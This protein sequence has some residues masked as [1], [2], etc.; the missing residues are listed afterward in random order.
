MK[1]KLTLICLLFAE[2]FSYA[3]SSSCFIDDTYS[4]AELFFPR[5][6]SVCMTMEGGVESCNPQFVFGD[7]ES[8]SILETI[9]LTA[10][11]PEW[12]FRMFEN[13]PDEEPA[14]LIIEVEYISL[15]TGGD[16]P[17]N[18][19][20]VDVV[21]GNLEYEAEMEVEIGIMNVP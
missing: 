11:P 1:S 17:T 12:C 15:N 16:W 20:F 6:Y 3:Q 4:E 21:F 7:G 10:Y 5:L 2:L 18:L 19:S 14:Q 13:D 9:Q 8:L